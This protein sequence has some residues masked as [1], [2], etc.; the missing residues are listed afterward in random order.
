MIR[1]LLSVLAAGLLLLQNDPGGGGTQVDASQKGRTTSVRLT[2]SQIKLSGDVKGGRGDGYRIKSPCWYEPFLNAED[3]FK[4]KSD[5][6]GNASRII[7]DERGFLE[8]IQ[9]FKDKVGQPGLWWVPAYDAGDPQGP[10]CWGGLELFVFV[11]PN[12]TP[13][14]GI[15]VQRLA[16][17]ARAA[18]TVPEPTVKLNPED[19]SF[20]NL[21]TWVWLE[22]VGRPRRSVTAMIPGV[23]SVTVVATLKGITIDPGAGSDRAEVRQDGCGASGKPYVKGGQF[24]CGVRYLRASLDQPR[25]SYRLTVTSEWPVEIAGQAAQAQLAPVRVQTTR[26]VQVG[27]IQSNVKP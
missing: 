20:V 11:P 19:K 5:P 8:Y 13:P 3:M 10:A 24:T 14:S 27:E 2:F 9:Q 21:P 17:I 18:L 4:L 15:T 7:A 22:G 12:T 16:E 25:T 6:R 1:P 26:D 23:M